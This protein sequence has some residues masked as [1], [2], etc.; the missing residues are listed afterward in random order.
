MKSIIAPGFGFHCESSQRDTMQKVITTLKDILTPLC[1]H[2]KD[3][4]NNENWRHIFTE[5]PLLAREDLE[6]LFM[7]A[8]TG[9]VDFSQL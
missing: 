3:V 2:Q 4:W 9:E 5:W 8:E 7:L 1:E 6:A